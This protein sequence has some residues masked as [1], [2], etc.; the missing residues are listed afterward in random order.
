MM[1]GGLHREPR[2]RC[3]ADIADQL[4]DPR[5]GILR[6]VRESRGEA[7]APNFFHYRAR[8]ANTGAFTAMTNF[9]QSAG[10]STRREV[11][12]SKA[13]GEAIERYCAA[14]Y[15]M[16]ELPL[17][18][19]SEAPF[20]CAAPDEFTLYSHAQYASPG[21]PWVAFD[22][23]TPVRWTPGV[24]LG[25]EQTC[26]V[27]AARVF[28]PYTYYEDAGDRPIDQPISTGLACHMSYAE[29]ARS[30]LAEVVERDAFLITWQAMIGPP[31]VLLET[32]SEVNRDLVQRFESTGSTVILFN[33]TLDH[34]IPTVLSVLLGGQPGA[35]AM[36]VAAAA[37]TDPEAAIRQSLEELALTRISSQYL[38]T[39]SPRIVPDP[40]LYSNVEDQRSHLHFWTDH[41]N[42]PL[43]DFLF[44][45]ER[46]IAFGEIE[47]LASDDAASDVKTMVDRIRKVGHRVIAVD[48]TTPDVGDLGLF[49][50]RTVVPGFH[51]LHIGHSR[52]ALGGTRLWTVPQQ[53]GYPGITRD[54]GDNPVPHPYP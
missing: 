40:P 21:F 26:F 23:N 15:E 18:S 20:P 19:Y 44:A 28:I 36:V 41:E 35:P 11:A 29:A 32:L 33:L 27:P 45:S 37:S 9:A 22:E 24:D 43:A 48:L 4:V 47:S 30:A 13:I 53:L 52:R 54:G 16:D 31:R 42:L 5:V 10:V 17:V 1:T 25:T 51:P 14:I 8:A 7:G 46:R 12:A 2:E 38:K 39:S 50:V 6:S 34:G 49:V 3:L